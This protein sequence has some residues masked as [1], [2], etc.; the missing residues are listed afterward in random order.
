[1]YRG[2]VS[3]EATGW[4]AASDGAWLEGGMQPCSHVHGTEHQEHEG[5][6]G[7]Q[8]QSEMTTGRCCDGAVG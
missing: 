2:W 7:D 4:V 6:S 8:E 5:I 1:M 3:L